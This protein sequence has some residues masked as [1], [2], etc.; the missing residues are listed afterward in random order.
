MYKHDTPLYNARSRVAASPLQVP[1]TVG[2]FVAESNG[3]PSEPYG[4]DLPP[5]APQ[6]HQPPPSRLE[7]LRPLLSGYPAQSGNWLVVQ[8]RAVAWPGVGTPLPSVCLRCPLSETC[9]SPC[10]PHP[11]IPSLLRGCFKPLPFPT[12]SLQR[13]AGRR[14]RGR[15][16][17]P[18][19]LP[20]NSRTTRR[21]HGRTLA[22]AGQPTTP[23]IAHDRLLPPALY[24][25][26]SFIACLGSACR[27]GSCYPWVCP[28]A[29]GPLLL[30]PLH[31]ARS[32]PSVPLSIPGVSPSAPCSLSLSWRSPRTARRS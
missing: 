17:R 9:V 14:L 2:W 8:I 12:Y 29:A 3:S 23:R 21:A 25:R 30:L 16:R 7:T 24:P 11:K 28:L 18:L 22:A 13:A 10:S 31:G 1:G 6:T 19:P 32:C 5:C 26:A 4:S 20:A 15:G 27:L